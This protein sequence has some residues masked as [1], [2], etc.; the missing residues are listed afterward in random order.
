LVMTLSEAERGR[1][2]KQ[3][4]YEI[5]D[6]E[7]TRAQLLDTLAEVK[8]N[9]QLKRDAQRSMEFRHQERATGINLPKIVSAVVWVCHHPIDKCYL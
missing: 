6:L 5:E 9:L 3:L 2:H 7:T 8:H 4:G 1:R